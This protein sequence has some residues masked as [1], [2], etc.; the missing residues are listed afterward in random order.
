MTSPRGK[1]EGAHVFIQESTDMSVGEG[2]LGSA[3][4]GRSRPSDGCSCKE[5]NLSQ[6]L[7]SH[8][9]QRKSKGQQ[10]KGKIVSEFF[11][12]FHTFSHFFQIFSPRAFPRQNKG[13]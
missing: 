3:V 4:D 7:S 5:L 1:L 2:A 10:L 11:T 6:D 9:C 8:I 12:L 13:V